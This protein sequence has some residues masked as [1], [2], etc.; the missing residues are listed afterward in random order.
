MKRRDYLAKGVIEGEGFVR[1]SYGD[2]WPTRN[3]VDDVHAA[4]AKLHL[5]Q[6]PHPGGN[7][8][9]YHGVAHLRFLI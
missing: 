4:V 3:H 1:I 7:F 8:D 2:L 5:R 6:G 9:G